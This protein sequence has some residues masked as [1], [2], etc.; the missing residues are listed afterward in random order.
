MADMMNT[1]GDLKYDGGHEHHRGHDEHDGGHE[2]DDS[3]EPDMKLSF[4]CSCVA[5][6]TNTGTLLIA[7][8]KH[9][10]PV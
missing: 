10:S 2:H 8:K 1:I 9:S 6:W 5:I 7:A 4:Q 3:H